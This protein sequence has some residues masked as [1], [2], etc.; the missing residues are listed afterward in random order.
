MLAPKPNKD[1]ISL[2]KTR[3]LALTASGGTVTPTLQKKVE[4]D[5]KSSL[6]D[7]SQRGTTATDEE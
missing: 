2:E 1:D 4:F 5:A 7:E 6:E 3:F